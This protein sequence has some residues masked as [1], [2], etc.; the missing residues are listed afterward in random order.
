MPLMRIPYTSPLPSPTVVP[1]SASTI[2]GA[3]SALYNF[4]T[5]PNATFRSGNGK[6][7]I[8]S[9]AGISVASGL[10]D[11]RGTK[12]TY[13]LNKTY[14]P[15]Y[16]HEFCASHEARKRYWARSFLGWTTLNTAKP[17]PAHHA[18]SGL[19]D[20]GTLSSVI[21][22]NVDSF[23]PKAH[24]KLKTLE[25][26][27]Y[28]RSN[29]CLTCRTEYD[30]AK[31]QKDL[32][33]LNPEW[34]AF[35]AEMLESGA[36]TTENP[37]E[38]KRRGLKTNP[39][40]D[41]DVPGVEYSTFRYPAC[42]KC[43]ANPPRD[44]K[45]ETDANGAWLPTS[46][47]GILKPAVI[48]FGE[49]IPDQ[50]KLAV[51]EAID[52]A[53]RI[54]ILGSSLATYSA[55]RLIKRAKEQGMPIAAANIGGIRGEEQFFQDLSPD[56]TGKDGVRCSLPLEQVLPALVQKME[57]EPPSMRLAALRN[58]NFTPAPWAYR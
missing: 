46:N 55:W 4:L 40:G 13:T 37:D 5:A 39:D 17:N 26:H 2:P 27:G 32:E 34:A 33:K 43:L 35:L 44:S 21:T 36:L 56:S 29:V 45:I 14:R 8:L 18:V 23:H 52:E 1:A 51:E 49:S 7:V 28:L 47:A 54:L 9:G 19:A 30:R 41:V 11:Y 20:W 10:A 53:S 50:V 58:G 38:R 24:P 25:L 12:G 15:I 16:F 31:F 48:M 3:V 57:Q 6:T 42:P 22:Q